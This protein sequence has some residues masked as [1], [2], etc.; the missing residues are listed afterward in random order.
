MALLIKPFITITDA[1]HVLIHGKIEYINSLLYIPAV[2]IHI[3]EIMELIRQYDLAWEIK[4]GDHA[5]LFAYYPGENW[6]F[7]SELE[8]T[9]SMLYLLASTSIKDHVTGCTLGLDEILSKQPLFTQCVQKLQ[10]V[11]ADYKNKT[12]ADRKDKAEE[13]A[14]RV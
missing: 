4:A 3:N 7:L 11:W 12:M 10:E 5:N 2:E 9:P 8:L 1:F 6:G 14:A 13:D